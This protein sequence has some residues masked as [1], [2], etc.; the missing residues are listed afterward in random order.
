MNYRVELQHRD[1]PLTKKNVSAS[2]ILYRF[3]QLNQSIYRFLFHYFIYSIL[4]MPIVLR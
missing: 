2:S 3:T 1:H 4:L